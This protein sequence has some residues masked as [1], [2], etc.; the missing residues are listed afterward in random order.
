VH[1]GDVCD[2]AR[3]RDVM[4]SVSPDAVAHLA[5]V[6][7]VSDAEADP[8]A[9]YR[10]NVGGTLGVLDALRTLAP[11]ARLLFVGSSAVYGEPVNGAILTEDAP[12][13]PRTVYGASKAAA[14]I[15]AAQWGRAYGLDVRRVR[16]FNHTGAGQDPRF[17]CAALARQVARIEAGLQPPV[18]DA[19]NLDPVR[20]FSDVRDVAAAYAAVLEHGTA[21]TV[22]NVC[23]GAGVSIAEVVAVL[24]THAR[25]AL[26]AHSD[27]ALRRRLDVPRLVGSAD[28]L[29]R[30]TGW[31]PA[32]PL[33]ETLAWVL[34]DWRRRVASEHA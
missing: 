7:A 6:T 20:D 31:R 17:V 11:S 33:D 26:R 12:I 22:Y 16:A 21:G 23:S 9:A 24:R 14:E 4:A 3:L 19:G 13:Q 25:V 10:T 5:A 1:L 18:L 27:P 29:R 8:Q 30:E 32:I 2:A 15:A 34:D 28:R